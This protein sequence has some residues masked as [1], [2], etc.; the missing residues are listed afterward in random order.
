MPEPH[1]QQDNEPN[2][3]NDG[4]A[5]PWQ[6]IGLQLGKERHGASTA[7]RCDIRDR[8]L[9]L[10]IAE[11]SQDVVGDLGDLPVVQNT[12]ICAVGRSC[13]PGNINAS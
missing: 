7:R 5:K 8:H 4:H 12:D 3:D 13:M 11:P 6:H 10:G 1:E 9:G 2:D